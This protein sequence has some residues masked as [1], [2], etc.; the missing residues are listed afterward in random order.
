MTRTR[1]KSPDCSRCLSSQNTKLYKML[2]GSA[3]FV[4]DSGFS[5]T[6]TSYHRVPLSLSLSLAY[7][8]PFS[9][10]GAHSERS[11]QHFWHSPDTENGKNETCP[12]REMTKTKSHRI[13]S[14]LGSGSSFASPLCLCHCVCLFLCL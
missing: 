8:V 7:R 4:L 3:F 9:I 10:S 6:E 1:W 5:K 14:Q 12:S 2:S 11:T 13:A